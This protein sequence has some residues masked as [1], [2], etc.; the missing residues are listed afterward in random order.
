MWKNL[1]CFNEQKQLPNNLYPPRSSALTSCIHLSPLS[2]HLW[3]HTQP[4]ADFPYSCQNSCKDTSSLRTPSLTLTPAASSTLALCGSP[5]FLL[6]AYFQLESPIHPLAP[7]YTFEI[8]D[9]CLFLSTDIQ[10]PW[11]FGSPHLVIWLMP[12][13]QMSPTLPSPWPE[14]V[15]LCLFGQKFKI[16]HSCFS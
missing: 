3:A 16:Q 2:A 11:V 1:F 14:R 15:L 9:F 10:P 7:A 8:P 4:R 12:R 6:L 13:P 5:G